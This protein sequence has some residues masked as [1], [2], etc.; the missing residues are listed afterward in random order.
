MKHLIP[1][2]IGLLALLG[3]ADS[4]YLTL[5]HF[6]VINPITLESSRV[7]LLKTGSCVNVVVSPLAAVAQQDHSPARIIRAS[8]SS[9]ELA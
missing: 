1:I 4:V 7:C 3:F 6:Q 5:A 9:I 2:I 8:V